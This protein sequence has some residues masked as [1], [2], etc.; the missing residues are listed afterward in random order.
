MLCRPTDSLF[1][2]GIMTQP[3]S[4]LNVECTW[5][6]IKTQEVCKVSW[7]W[8][9]KCFVSN[10]LQVWYVCLSV[11]TVMKFNTVE[12][13][14]ERQLV[15]TLY[16]VISKSSCRWRNAICI[17]WL[18]REAPAA[19]MIK[20]LY[21]KSSSQLSSERAKKQHC[22]IFIEPRLRSCCCVCQPLHQMD[23]RRVI[24]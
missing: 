1:I 21:L 17:W 12:L 2:F 19:H 7:C 3:V 15:F 13:H 20:D 10:N 14:L 4:G 8:N 24:R 22:V 5:W 6:D 23:G 16:E 11:C 9:M 18:L